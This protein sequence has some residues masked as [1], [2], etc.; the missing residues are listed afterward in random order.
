MKILWKWAVLEAIV[1]ALILSSCGRSEG[2]AVGDNLHR[3]ESN[4]SID[5]SEDAVIGQ[6]RI[7]VDN[8]RL[9]EDIMGAIM[10]DAW[11]TDINGKGVELSELEITNIKVHEVRF[12]IGG[13]LADSMLL[14]LESSRL[15]IGNA[16]EDGLEVLLGSMLLVD[17]ANAQ[18]LFLPSEED[19][20]GWVESNRPDRMFFE[21]NLRDIFTPDTPL[22]VSYEILFSYE[23]TYLEREPKK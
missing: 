7:Y 6:G 1:L 4:E 23:Y 2:T 11:S 22:P 5:L 13:G 10:A 15:L 3:Y 9:Y 8:T 21:Y 14:Y 18:V 17:V 16:G 19:L 12:D 20:T